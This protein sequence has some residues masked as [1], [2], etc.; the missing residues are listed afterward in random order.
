MTRKKK[1]ESPNR[2][3]EFFAF[4]IANKSNQ[5]VLTG[6]KKKNAAELL[7]EITESDEY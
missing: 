1:K 6:E 2:N 4:D 7:N 5:N 3:E